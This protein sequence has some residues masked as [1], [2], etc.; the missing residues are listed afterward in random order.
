MTGRRHRHHRS[1]VTGQIVCPLVHEPAALEQIRPVVCRFHLVPDGVRQRGLRDSRGSAARSAAQSRKLDR[2]P[3]GTAPMFRSRMSLD[4]V[5]SESGLPT[6]VPGKTRLLVSS[7]DRASARICMAR[8]PSGTRCSCLAFIRSAG[9]CPGARF[10]VDFV[11][12]REPN[13]TRTRGC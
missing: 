1:R 8:A 2:N 10:G 3:C 4:S 9:N 13:L 11:P 7:I 6:R 5:I 12:S